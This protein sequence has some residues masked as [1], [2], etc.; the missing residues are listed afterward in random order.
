MLTESITYLQRCLQIPS[1][2]PLDGEENVAAYVYD[3]L[4][5]HG[6]ETEWIE[7]VT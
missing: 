3:L 7:G 2:N 5:S 1:T 4:T 6:I